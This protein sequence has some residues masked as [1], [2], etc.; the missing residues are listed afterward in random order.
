MFIILKHFLPVC[1]HSELTSLRVENS[2]ANWGELLCTS[3][4]RTPL[5]ALQHAPVLQVIYIYTRCL[6]DMLNFFCLQ[7]THF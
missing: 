4:G 7:D 3:E 6:Q 2:L 5:A 1:V